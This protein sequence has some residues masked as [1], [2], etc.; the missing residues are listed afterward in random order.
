M[1][2]KLRVFRVSSV[3]RKKIVARICIR[4]ECGECSDVILADPEKLH[5]LAAC[6]AGQVD[7]G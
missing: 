7:P 2:V 1:R 4:R 5:V 3:G 6:K